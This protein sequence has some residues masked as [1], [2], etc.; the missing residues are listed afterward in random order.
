LHQG[1]RNPRA[2]PA[3]R[4][5]AL[6]RRDLSQALSPSVSPPD[7]NS[8]KKGAVLGFDNSLSFPGAGSANRRANTVNEA[9]HLPRDRSVDE[10]DGCHEHAHRQRLQFSGH[11]KFAIQPALLCTTTIILPPGNNNRRCAESAIHKGLAVAIAWSMDRAFSPESI[12]VAGS[13]ALPQAGMEPR[14]WR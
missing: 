8:P 14:R 10:G 5:A 2:A 4:D 7:L 9:R 11:A 3:Y 12:G 1:G 6:D 13:D